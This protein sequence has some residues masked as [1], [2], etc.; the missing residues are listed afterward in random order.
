MG[1]PSPYGPI[2]VDFSSPY[3]VEINNTLI[4]HDVTTRFSKPVSGTT[5]SEMI[6]E[7]NNSHEL[8]KFN[9][10]ATKCT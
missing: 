6:E 7:G 3:H 4:T 5:A 2:N 10:N 1:S 8:H 9:V